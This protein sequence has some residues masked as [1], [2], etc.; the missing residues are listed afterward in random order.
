MNHQTPSTETEAQAQFIE[1]MTRF[2]TDPYGFVL[3]SY[4]WGQPGTFLAADKDGVVP[5]PDTWQIDIME[6]LRLELERRE[7]TP[8]EVFGAIQIAVSSGHGI[9]KSALLSWLIHWFVCC[10]PHPQ[11]RV[12]AG[13]GSQLQNTIWRELAKWHKVS[14]Q[15]PWFTWT[16]TKFFLKE[17]PETW[18]VNAMAWSEH[19]SDAFGGLHEKYVMVIF[20]EASAVADIIWETVEGALTTF[21]CIWIVFGNPIRNTGRFKACF[22]KYRDLWIRRKVDSRTAKMTNKV[23]LEKYRKQYGEDSDYFR[24]RVRGEFP[25]QSTNQLISEQAVEKCRALVLPGYEIFPIRI[26]CDVARSDDGDKTVIMVVQGRKILE[27]I[28]MQIRDTL[29]IY[30]KLVECWNFWNKRCDNI[31]VFVDDIGVGGG[32]T[33]MLKKVSGM[34]QIPIIAGAEPSDPVRFLNLRMNMWWDMMEAIVEGI[35]MTELSEDHYDRLKSDLTNIEYFLIPKNQ[36]Y[37]LEG[38]AEIKERSLPS[39]DYGTALAQT[40]AYPVP[41]VSSS[42][43]ARNARTDNRGGSSTLRKK[44]GK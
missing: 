38:V 7:H 2:R 17:S 23:Q 6:T 28:S 12:T 19:N 9:G 39:P 29:A 14:L 20:D 44:R 15:E 1:S 4:P 40:F 11:M 41:L 26:S 5:C 33:D 36:K 24:K 42:W 35:D 43:Q 32:V 21:L 37:Q 27:C 22:T 13:T 25:V 31:T 16:A 18:F 30:T 10:Y 8:E 3:Y 34:R